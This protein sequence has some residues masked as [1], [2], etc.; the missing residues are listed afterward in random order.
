MN[1]PLKETRKKFRLWNNTRILAAEQAHY[2]AVFEARGLAHPDDAA[3]LS[4]MK[5]RFPDLA[6]QTEGRAFNNCHLSQLQRG[7]CLS[8]ARLKTIRG[9]ASL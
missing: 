8:V 4:A 2:E 5:K 7:G 1:D 3:I 6:P 9:G